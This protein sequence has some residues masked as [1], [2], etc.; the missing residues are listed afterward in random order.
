MIPAIN[1]FTTRGFEGFFAFAL[2]SCSL[3]IL[4]RL[5]RH[6][7]KLIARSATDIEPGADSL[8]L[9]SPRDPLPQFSEHT[10]EHE[11][12]KQA[13]QYQ[14]PL[15]RQGDIGGI[16]IKNGEHVPNIHIPFFSRFRKILRFLRKLQ[17][18]LHALG[19]KR[20][21]LESNQAKRSCNPFPYRLGRPPTA[22]A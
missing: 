18:V 3:L 21:P 20:R 19:R 7:L 5:P 16:V 22:L 8:L 11:I 15:R 6:P 13:G 1:D 4:V 14:N 2:P 17:P 10:A 9:D 12:I